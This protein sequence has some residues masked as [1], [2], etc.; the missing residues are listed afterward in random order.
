M[1]SNPRFKFREAEAVLEL[2]HAFTRDFSGKILTWTA[3]AQKVYQWTPDEAVGRISHDLLRTKFP[4]PLSEINAELIRTGSWEGELAHCRKDG[5]EIV[6]A[7]HWVTIEGDEGGPSALLEINNDVTDSRRLYRE[8]E[9]AWKIATTASHAKDDFLA[10]LSHELRNPL[11]PITLAINSLAARGEADSREIQIIKRQADHLTRLVDDLLDV[12]RLASGKLELRPDHAELSNVIASAVEGVRPLIESR[13]H[14]L[15]LQ[16]PESG[17]PM[18]G[19]AARL[20]QVFANLLNNAARYTPPGGHISVR[21]ERV[22]AD[23]IVEVRDDG[24]GIEPESLVHL[25]EMFFQTPR[26]IDRAKGG[27]GLGLTLVKRLVEM[28]GGQVSAASA[29]EGQGSRFT[30]KLPL[31]SSPAPFE[32]SQSS[33]I[34]SKNRL[35]ILVVE[36]YP[37][38]AETVSELL[39][40]HGHEVVAVSDGLAALELLTGFSPDVAVIDIGLPVMDGYELARR[41]AEKM[42]ERTPSMIALSGYG[43]PSDLERSRRGGFHLHLV[44]PIEAEGMIKALASLPMREQKIL[45]PD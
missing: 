36:D 10:M 2:A 16:I 3:G 28:H 29:G 19:D 42:P 7:S 23:V 30:V 43:Q 25:F 14:H 31:S 12:E 38:I 6:V 41:I 9:S 32:L 39:G 27:L 34:A 17:L 13:G 18:F 15:D 4:K 1:D 44:K 26:P 20:R 33:A 11:T 35:K 45:Q 21:A 40:Q 5:A 8:L 22:G 24:E 37:D